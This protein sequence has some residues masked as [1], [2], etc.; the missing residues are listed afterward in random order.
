M[1][2]VFYIVCFCL[3]LSFSFIQSAVAYKDMKLDDV[4]VA[5]EKGDAAAQTK[6]GVAYSTGINVEINKE[7][8]VKWYKKAA[9]QGYATGQWNLAFM[10]IRGEGVEANDEKAREWFLKAAEQGFAP[11]EY[12]LGMMCLYGM[13][14]KR[15]RVEALK[16]VRLSADKGY[17]EAIG[18]L[19]AQGELNPEKKEKSKEGKVPKPHLQ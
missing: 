17:N 2:K 15:S 5:A 19:R 4:R 16:W 14:G 11:A 8:A 9:E 10:Y 13:G 7:E 12:D 3:L 1:K 18:F 6:L